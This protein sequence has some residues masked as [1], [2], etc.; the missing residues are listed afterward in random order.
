MTNSFSLIVKSFPLFL[1]GMTV[2]LELFILASVL[3]IIVGILLGILSCERLK[4]PIITKLING[5]TFISRAVPFY[6]Q[7]LII[8]FVIPD[9]FGFSLC[10]FAASITA[11][12]IC[13]SGYVAQFIRG[14]INTLPSSHW[15]TASVLGYSKWQ[16]LF[17]IIL[18]Q[19]LR[20]ALPS[21]NNE[22]E[23]LLKSTAIASSIGMLEL[24]RV[25]MN[26]VSREMEPVPIYLAIAVLYGSLS[27]ILNVW[28][29]RLEKR[30]SYVKY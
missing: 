16:I 21:L 27:A 19:S 8:Y 4:I 20:L 5:W 29:K 14:A 3:S 24:T 7:L 2:T 11:L 30:F 25:G 15:E 28:T 1:K 12:G 17:E 13:S 6:V 18:P 23:S 9:L 22:F 10:P 26:I